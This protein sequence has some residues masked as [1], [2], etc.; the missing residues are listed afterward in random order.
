MKQNRFSKYIAFIKGGLIETFV[1]KYQILGWILG[2]FIQVLITVSLWLAV[3]ENSPNEEINGFTLPM[4]LSYLIIIKV[5]SH[6]VYCS[7]A[8]WSVGED[9]REGNISIQLVRPL[10]YRNRILSSDIGS[11]IANIIITFIPLF[12]ISSTVL[13]FTLDVPFPSVINVIL[14]L[15]SSFMSFLI[16]SLF[17]FL[18]GQLAFYTGALFGLFILKDELTFFLS[19]GLIPLS[20]FP[21]VIQKIMNFLPFSSILETPTF[22]LTNRYEPTEILIKLAIQLIWVVVFFILSDLS[23]K[24]ASRRLQTTGG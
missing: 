11:Y 21:E 10:S 4:M 18:L 9:I 3:Y 7:N 22:I 20:F 1:Y 15:I 24:R 17:S 23:F 19:G 12:I 14:F 13:Y 2:D 5:V 6:L 16:F 8:F